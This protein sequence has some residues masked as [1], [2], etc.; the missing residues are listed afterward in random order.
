MDLA[1]A[2][3]TVWITGASGGIGR[4]LAEAFADEG[5]NLC[6]HANTALK[7]TREWLE[8]KPWK[9]RV[10]LHAVDVR[11]AAGVERAALELAERFGRIDVCVANAGI[12]P[13][14]NVGLHALDTER[15][16]E[17]IDVNLLGALWTARAFLKVLADKGPRADGHGAALLFTGSTAGRF[18]EKYHVDYA[19][20]KA[21]LV[22]VLLSLKNEIVELDPHARV[23]LVEPGWTV[24]HMARPVMDVAGAIE[25]VTRTMALRQLARA[26][27]IARTMLWLA[28]PVA[29]SHITG[30][31]VTCAGG[32]EGRLLWDEGQVD[33]EEILRRLERD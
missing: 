11:D 29:S 7:P 10:Q 15:V 24:T 9:E 3:K 32:M 21:A 12:W 30:Q 28:S 18:G 6:L 13:Q 1:L 14:G 20:S 4:A 17:T 27:D 22:G 2:G 23:N 33:R 19:A 31:T 8:E 26:K 16:R 5:A 25:R